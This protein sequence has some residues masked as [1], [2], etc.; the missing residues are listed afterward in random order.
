MP[1]AAVKLRMAP[2]TFTTGVPVGNTRT[3]TSETTVDA[4]LAEVRRAWD[5][6]LPPRDELPT[7]DASTILAV[8]LQEPDPEGVETLIS[9]EE[10]DD[11]SLEAGRERLLAQLQQHP[12]TSPALLP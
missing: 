6:Q 2:P 4:F 7:A 11:A 12:P 10:G 1:S 3:L 8:W 5:G 9:L